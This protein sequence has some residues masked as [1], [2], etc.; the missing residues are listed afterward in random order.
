MDTDDHF[1]ERT[2]DMIAIYR[3]RV[4]GITF[5]YAAELLLGSCFPEFL[6]SVETSTKP[7]IEKNNVFFA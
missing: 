4:P 2:A 5:Q 3:K 6:D 1:A 7:M